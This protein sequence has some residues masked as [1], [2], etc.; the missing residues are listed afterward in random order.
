MSDGGSGGGSDGGYSLASSDGSAAGI[1]FSSSDSVS[2]V[3]LPSVGVYRT[4][5]RSAVLPRSAVLR[6]T[7]LR[8]AVLLRQGSVTVLRPCSEPR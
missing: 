3:V 4:A 7:V 2:I 5:V 8:S 6:S 1:A